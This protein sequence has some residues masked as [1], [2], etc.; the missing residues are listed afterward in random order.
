VL[1]GRSSRPDALR[2]YG[3]FST[4]HRRKFE[5]MLRV[6]RLIPRVPPRLL[7]PAIVAMSARRFVDWSFTHYLNIAPP[8]F[9]AAPAPLPAERVAAA[10]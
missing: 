5:A 10:A 1:A 9:A 3:E 6:Q 2:R 7:G 8:S 4:S